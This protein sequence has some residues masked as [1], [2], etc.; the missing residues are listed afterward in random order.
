MRKVEVF[1]FNK[2]GETDGKIEWKKSSAGIGSF[3]GLGV[4]Y[5]ESYGG[6]IQFT[7]A[8]VEM[9]DGFIQNIKVENVRFVDSEEE[10]NSQIKNIKHHDMPF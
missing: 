4:G 3:L 10:D 5:R 6:I 1:K 2:S 8:V 7:T 9:P